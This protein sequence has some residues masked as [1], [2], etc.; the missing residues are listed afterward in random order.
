[1]F[2]SQTIKAIASAQR[3][4]NH[5]LHSYPMHPHP[6]QGNLWVMTPSP[7]FKAKHLAGQHHYLYFTNRKNRAQASSDCT[8]VWWFSNDTVLAPQLLSLPP[9]NPFSIPA[10]TIPVF[11]MHIHSDSCPSFCSIFDQ[12]IFKCSENTLRLR[13]FFSVVY[14]LCPDTASWPRA[15]VSATQFI[16]L[17]S[18][19]LI[20]HNWVI[21]CISFSKA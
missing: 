12:I 13:P 8:C 7:V 10:V 14:L 19:C 18:F 1:M 3:R 2:L 5:I 4:L 11:H 9:K 15:A 20:L 16:V 6:L 21:H 17:H